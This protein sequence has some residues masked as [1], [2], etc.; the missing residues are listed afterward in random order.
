MTFTN[1][2]SAQVNIRLDSELYDTLQEIAKKD[3][4]TVSQLVRTAVM[5][6]YKLATTA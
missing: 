5:R 4:T 1:M 6:E 3:G 2:Q